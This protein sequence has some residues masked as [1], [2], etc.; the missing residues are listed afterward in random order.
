MYRGENIESHALHLFLL[1]APDYLGYPNA[2][3]MAARHRETVA[4]GLRLKKLGNTL[5]EV[6]GGR[7]IHPVNP[8]VGGFGRVPSTDE[9]LGL[10]RDLECGMEDCEVALEAL[11]SLPSADFCLAPTTFAALDVA[12][13]GGYYAGDE[14]V[15]LEGGSRTVLPACSYPSFTNERVVS[16]SHAKHSSFQGEPVMVGA[17]ARL[18][19]HASRLSERALS[20][21]DRLGLRLPSGNPMDNN[22][23]QAVELTSD[24]E[25][26]LRSV[27]RLLDEGLESERAAPVERGGGTGWA[28]TEAPRGLL[29]YRISID[30]EGR[31]SGADV[32]TPTAINA[33][34]IER[35]LRHTVEQSEEPDSQDLRRR[36]EMIARAYDPCISCSVHVLRKG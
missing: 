1:A 6:L 13:T 12:D 20:A 28:A 4:V 19:V 17:L 18:S 7:A 24:V 23:A 36:L 5:Q 21:M 8:V 3:A 34:C 22:K 2:V 35:H 27:R 9:L 31:V 33:A 26:A 16:H 30:D 29:L 25:H 32:I 11:A 14:L 10:E 15:V